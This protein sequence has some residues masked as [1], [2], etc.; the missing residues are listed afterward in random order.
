MDEGEGE[1]EG[2]S[3]RIGNQPQPR[4]RTRNVNITQRDGLTS[5]RGPGPLRFDKNT[6]IYI[7]IYL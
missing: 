3:R 5:G 1:G 7:N 6:D 2:D 4:R